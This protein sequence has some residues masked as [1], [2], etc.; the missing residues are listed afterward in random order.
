VHAISAAD[1][2]SR[3]LESQA[4][5]EPAAAPEDRGHR[6]LAGPTAA[7]FQGFSW[8]AAAT[9]ASELYGAQPAE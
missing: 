2:W 9:G 7:T 5:D 1:A 3:F 6:S 4:H 8:S